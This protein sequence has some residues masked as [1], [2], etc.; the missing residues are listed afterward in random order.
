ME[1]VK[2]YFHEIIVIIVATVLG[3]IMYLIIDGYLRNPTE[4]SPTDDYLENLVLA[5]RREV[6]SLLLLNR[7][8]DSANGKLK[9]EV[10]ILKE[11]VKNKPTVVELKRTANEKY[12][13]APTL[14]DDAIRFFNE[15]T[16]NK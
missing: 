5:K 15:W 14:F 13:S 4:S 16:D 6:D 3:I 9:K 12:K 7:K 8:I 10:D 2:K 11:E 1:F